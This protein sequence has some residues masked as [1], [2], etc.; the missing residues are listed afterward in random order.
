MLKCKASH[1]QIFNEEFILSLAP[2]SLFSGPYLKAWYCI[3]CI[4]FVLV[5][6]PRGEN[7]GV[8]HERIYTVSFKKPEN[9]ELRPKNHEISVEI[10][11]AFVSMLMI[12]LG[13]LHVIPYF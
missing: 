2:L 13:P 4:G 5:Q 3:W 9:Y 7:V 8:Y 10:T 6:A 11:R 12:C 1:S